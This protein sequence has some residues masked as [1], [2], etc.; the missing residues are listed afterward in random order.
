[1]KNILALFILIFLF[2]SCQKK[3]DCYSCKTTFNV[4]HRDSVESVSWSV[5]DTKDFCDMTEDRIREYEARN[6]DTLVEVSGTVTTTTISSTK[7]TK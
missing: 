1:M 6:T 5:S 2:F 3:P 7:C 4:T